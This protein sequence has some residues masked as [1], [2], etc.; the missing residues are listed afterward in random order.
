MYPQYN[1]NTIIKKIL[2]NISNRH[3]EQLEILTWNRSNRMQ[4]R[5]IE[6]ELLDAS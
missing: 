5:N 2:M 4:K 6:K 1:N 3:V